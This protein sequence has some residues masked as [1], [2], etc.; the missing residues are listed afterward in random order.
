MVLV[1]DVLYIG[2]IFPVYYGFLPIICSWSFVHQSS[3]FRVVDVLR[4]ASYTVFAYQWNFSS[5]L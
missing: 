1:V 2:G 3:M 4:A 5:L